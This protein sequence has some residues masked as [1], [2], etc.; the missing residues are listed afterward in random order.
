MKM[1]WSNILK[2]NE[3]HNIQSD[4]SVLE[5]TPRVLNLGT[6]MEAL[7]YLQEKKKGSDFVMS[8]ASRKTTGLDEIEKLSEE[9]KIESKVLE[10]LALIQQDAYQKGFDLGVE[11]GLK[12]AY[13]EKVNELNEQIVSFQTLSNHLVQL[14]SE[15]LHQNEAHLIKLVYELA[16]RLTFDHV[17]ENPEAILKIMKSAI[18]TAQADE[19]INIFVSQAQADLIEHL[20]IENKPDNDFLQKVKILASDKISIGS[21]I[22]ETNYGIVDAQIE[23]RVELLW[24]ELKVALPKIKTTLESA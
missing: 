10:K 15:M 23:K 21:C 14:K 18:D 16:S 22:I 1:Q 17:H 5:Y 4:V 7:A 19:N 13:D 12:K 3:V 24:N 11:E 2:K 8:D 9:R 20:K 6:P